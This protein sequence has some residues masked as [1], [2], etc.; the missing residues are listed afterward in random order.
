MKK[1][2]VPGLFLLIFLLSACADRGEAAVPY[3]ETR[4]EPPALQVQYAHQVQTFPLPIETPVEQFAVANER[5]FALSVTHDPMTAALYS[6]DLSGGDLRRTEIPVSGDQGFFIGPRRGSE[7]TLWLLGQTY[8]YT[9]EGERTGYQA[10]LFH[11]DSAHNVLDKIHLDNLDGETLVQD[12]EADAE[13]NIYLLRLPSEGG[14]EILVYGDG[15][16]RPLRNAAR[17]EA[18]IHALIRVGDRVYTGGWGM[19]AYP[20]ETSGDVSDEQAAFHVYG[21][22]HSSFDGRLYYTSGDSGLGGSGRN[23]YSRGLTGDAPWRELSWMEVGIAPDSIRSLMILEDGRLVAALDGNHIAV[24]TPIDPD[25]QSQRVTLT[26]ATAAPGA[27]LEAAIA[28]F[29]LEQEAY[30]IQVQDYS[31]YAADP[32]AGYRRLR[33][34]LL[35]GEVFDLIDL[36]GFSVEEFAML[37]LL[38]DL[39][40]LIDGAC[41]LERED[42]VS[43]VRT[44]LEIDG[45]LYALPA[46]FYL[47]TL[48]GGDDTPEHAAI[49]PTA[50]SLGLLQIFTMLGRS[51]LIG[52]RRGETH[53]TDDWFVELLEYTKTFGESAGGTQDLEILHITDFQEIPLYAALLDGLRFAGFPSEHGHHHGFGTGRSLGMSAAGEHP[54]AAWAFIRHLI[55]EDTGWGFPILVHALDARID[56]AMTTDTVESWGMGD[57]IVE[58]G[59]VSQAEV[60]LVLDL[61]GLT[62]TI[63]EHDEI[64]WAVIEEEALGFY[65]GEQ[66]AMEA[67][68]AMDRRV[69]ALW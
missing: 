29:H 18:W 46:V 58:I 69:R 30:R 19:G 24:L 5:I 55:Q 1:W 41:A 8:A 59:A 25:A 61:I 9:P 43:P 49:R 32:T 38:R 52:I 21:V 47:V 42:F 48:G 27:D 34:A 14:S 35:E 66:S 4:T 2:C 62:R 63:M 56:E 51:E 28:Q 3:A 12:M 16:E 64:I 54:L 67:A 44:A 33:E 45:G 10:T 40:D 60:D 20:V 37:G 15:G 65:M 17:H 36:S 23:L 53:F 26:L 39:Y 57:L 11:F 13:G 31:R 50:D 6:A 68:A 7:G 22:V